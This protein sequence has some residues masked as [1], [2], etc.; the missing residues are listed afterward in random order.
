M[1]CAYWI[2]LYRIMINDLSFD[3]MNDNNNDFTTTR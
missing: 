1:K 3:E 2:V